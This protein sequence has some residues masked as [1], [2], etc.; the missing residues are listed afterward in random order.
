MRKNEIH[1]FMTRRSGNETVYTVPRHCGACVIF[2][3]V[4]VGSATWRYGASTH[5]YLLSRANFQR[6]TSGI[7]YGFAT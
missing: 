3:S 2:L 7:T 6:V 4:A 1:F 5:D